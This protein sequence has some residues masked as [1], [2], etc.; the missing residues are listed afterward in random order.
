MHDKYLTGITFNQFLKSTYMKSYFN[1]SYIQS[2]LLDKL[3]EGKTFPYTRPVYIQQLIGLKPELTYFIYGDGSLDSLGMSGGKFRDLPSTGWE[4][5]IKNNL[6]NLYPE[7]LLEEN[8]LRIGRNMILTPKDPSKTM[9]LYLTV[10][11]E[12]NDIH[13]V[14]ALIERS[15]IIKRVNEYYVKF[16][17]NTG[18]LIDPGRFMISGGILNDLQSMI[19]ETPKVVSMFHVIPNFKFNIYFDNKNIFALETNVKVPP[20]TKP[21][22]IPKTANFFEIKL[23]N[24][25]INEGSTAGDAKKQN[26]ASMMGKFLADGLQYVLT[27]HINKTLPKNR[28]LRV[29][30]SGDG[31]ALNNYLFFSQLLNVT[32]TPMIIDRLLTRETALIAFNISGATTGKYISRTNNYASTL[33]ENPLSISGS[34]N[35]NND[36]GSKYNTTKTAIN[37]IKNNYS[38]L[39]NRE[40]QL[41]KAYVLNNNTDNVA[42]TLLSFKRTP[43]VQ[44]TELGQQSRK[45]S[46]R[47]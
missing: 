29:F 18:T 24:R 3:S 25:P 17:A 34:S 16:C 12:Q 6:Q 31:M 41:F 35:E 8:Q 42:Q 44:S 7:L 38:K 11:Q 46:K 14:S 22:V 21:G 28:N 23:N 19:S 40:K 1:T 45:R 26:P 10:D 43:S 27:A 37:K 30:C 33:G 4:A 39:S 13:G 36:A 15:P 20:I 47:L 5:V 2:I 32:K 9:K